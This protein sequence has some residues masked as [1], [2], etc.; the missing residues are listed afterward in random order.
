M[1]AH[2]ATQTRNGGAAAETCKYKDWVRRI[3]MLPFD[4]L[5]SEELQGVWYLSWVAAV[6]F[7]EALRLSQD[8]YP[9]HIGLQTMILGEL[10]TAN[11]ALDEF[12]QPA[13]HHQ[14]LEFFLRKHGV[15]ET[16]GAKLGE[17]AERYLAACRALDPH[18][19]AMTIFSREEELSGIFGRILDAPDWSAEGLYAFRHYLTNHIVLDSSEGGHHDLV[20][21][22]EVDDRVEPFYRAR[23]ESFRLIPALRD[24]GA[25]ADS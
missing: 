18:T 12:Q 1:T 13:D 7:A 5:T 10:E 8:L 14:F 22:F 16:E 3:R 21:D 19:R 23:F 9:D 25:Y 17:H 20:S 4:K 6:E 2:H 24:S 15:M 11:L